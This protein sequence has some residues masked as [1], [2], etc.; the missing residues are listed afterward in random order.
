M[1][2]ITVEAT[3]TPQTVPLNRSY[4]ETSVV[5]CMQFTA[6]SGCTSMTTITAPRTGTHTT[7]YVQVDS[8]ILYVVNVPD[9]LCPSQTTSAGMRML[10]NCYCSIVFIRFCA[11]SSV[12]NSM[13]QLARRQRVKPHY[14]AYCSST[15]TSI[16]VPNHSQ[17][18]IICEYVGSLLNHSPPSFF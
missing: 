11:G 15:H 9:I 16:D 10:A 12:V 13:L 4:D 18:V 6:A 17:C 7:F 1:E 3:L 14:L 8:S 2:F 5:F